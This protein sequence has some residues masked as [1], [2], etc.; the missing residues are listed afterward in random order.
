VRETQREE[1]SLERTNIGTWLLTSCDGIF[2]LVH[3]HFS[4]KAPGSRVQTDVIS[5]GKRLVARDA[6]DLGV[7]H[8][9]TTSEALLREA[10]TMVKNSYKGTPG[11]QREM[12]KTMKE[13]TYAEILQL[14]DDRPHLALPSSLSKL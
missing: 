5:F 4:F 14:F 9:T 8:K 10:I 12:L 7:V 2:S 11:L 6:L 1:S 13:D 3:C